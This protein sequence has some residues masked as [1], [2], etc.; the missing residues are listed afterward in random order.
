MNMISK[1]KQTQ[2]R[3]KKQNYIKM[4]VD[5]LIELTFTDFTQGLRQHQ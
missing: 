3:T 2:I 4:E 1:I 5:D